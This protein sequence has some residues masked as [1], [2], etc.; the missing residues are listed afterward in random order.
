M[1]VANEHLVSVYAITFRSTSA[2]KWTVRQLFFIWNRIV[3]I[4]QLEFRIFH[5][6]FHIKQSIYTCQLQNW[7]L[8]GLLLVFIQAWQPCSARSMTSRFGVNYLRMY[9][10]L[11]INCII[12]CF[13]NW[14]RVLLNNVY[15]QFKTFYIEIHTESYFYC[16]L[17]RLRSIAAHRDHFVR[18]LSVR[19]CVCPVVTLSWWPCIDIYM[20]RKRLMHTS[21]SCHYVIVSCVH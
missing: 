20:V 6:I 13:T 5:R 7:R 3:F 15:C 14:I 17:C 8:K 2:K 21:E 12:N 1:A 9:S 16:A 4:L 11:V 19:L 10:I 18:H